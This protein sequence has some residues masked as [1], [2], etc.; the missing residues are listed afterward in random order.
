MWRSRSISLATALLIPV[1]SVSAQTVE[2]TSPRPDRPAV[3]DLYLDG[4]T[5][6][7]ASR[8]QRELSRDSLVRPDGNTDR[9]PP[10]KLNPGELPTPQNPKAR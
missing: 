7:S 1:I 3:R 2:G 5:T 9:A 8:Q 10:S 4:G 6:G